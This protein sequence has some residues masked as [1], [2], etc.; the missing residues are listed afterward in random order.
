[1]LIK[2]VRLQNWRSHKDTVLEFSKG[3]NMLVGIM[4]SGKS[5]VLEGICFALYGTF[6]ALARKR[7]KLS[8]IVS[9]S[10]K[11]SACK[12]EVVF[13]KD[14]KEYTVRRVIEDGKGDAELRE[15]QRMVEAKSEAVT[16][17]V[18]HILGVDYDMFTKAIYSEQN[19]LDYFLSL[20]PGDR[21][22][23]MD[24][25][26]G[27]DRFELARANAT[28]LINRLSGEIDGLEK[29]IRTY[30]KAAI[31]KEKEEAEALLKGIT[32][33]KDAL[34]SELRAVTASE[35]E[36]RKRKEMLENKRKEHEALVR[37]QVECDAFISSVAGRVKGYTKEDGVRLEKDV[38][39]LE[40]QAARLRADIAAKE[41]KVAVC[42]RMIGEL[43]ASARLASEK[44]RELEGLKK[45]LAGLGECGDPKSMRRDAD[46]LSAQLVSLE[47]SH[48]SLTAEIALLRKDTQRLE[49]EIADAVRIRKDAEMLGSVHQRALDDLRHTEASTIEWVASLKEMIKIT[50]DSVAALEK[51]EGGLCPLCDSPLDKKKKETLIAKKREI[52][53]NSRK[54]LAETEARL[55]KIRK[56][57]HVMDAGLKRKAELAMILERLEQKEGELREKS[58]KA[59]ALEKQAAGTA[60]RISS[61][62]NEIAVVLE[63]ARKAEEAEL[64]RQKIADAESFLAQHR[65]DDNEVSRLK[66]D[67]KRE[68]ESLAKMRGLLAEAEKSLVKA[69][70][71][72]EEI[73]RDLGLQDEIQSKRAMLEEVKSSIA[74]LGYDDGELAS[75]STAYNGLLVKKKEIEMG[76]AHTAAAADL[77]VKRL[78]IAA[79]QIAEIEGKEKELDGLRNALAQAKEFQ[80]SI[81][82]TQ[83]LLRNE[84]VNSINSV[85][86]KVWAVMYPYGDLKQVV[87]EATE[88]DYLLKVKRNNEWVA[89]EGNVS[90]GER[91]SAAL[92]LRVALSIVL[93]PNMS[94]L[95]LDEPTHNLDENGVRALSEILRE[96]LPSIIEQVFV[97]THDENLKEG[98]SGRLYVFSRNKVAGEPTSVMAD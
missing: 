94:L 67:Y 68:S 76:I 14:G 8:Q 88:S 30:D 7:V 27:I 86:D 98:A 77:A 63:N 24:A 23:Q 29:K 47:K 79:K 39:G 87:I 33:K 17:M 42:G 57:I 55:D 49:G 4:G 41:G 6:P 9:E 74:R 28:K 19:A 58:A 37:R 12:V 62:K 32:E 10:A 35:D 61:L 70:G 48:S 25:L 52:V 60:A 46:M 84:L 64:L 13:Q 93:A 18:E 59:S 71:V 3:T 5:S 82:E 96:R 31:T 53:E 45:R 85:L 26:I 97:I 89:V 16:R 83:V 66:E 90:G 95:V 80:Q 91:A 43:E 54:E 50:L 78:D 34:T 1:M 73:S 75:A 20:N 51:E 22:K 15:G 38:A 56:D 81:I 2:S 21:K 40:E 44:M 65:A 72:A 92:A 69:K 36:M 11:G